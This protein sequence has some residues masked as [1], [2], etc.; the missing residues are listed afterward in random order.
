MKVCYDVIL[1]ALVLR[2]IFPVLN[3]QSST[4]SEQAAPTMVKKPPFDNAIQGILSTDGE[5]KPPPNQIP[6]ASQQDPSD[7]K[8]MPM[9]PMKTPRTSLMP[10]TGKFSKL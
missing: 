4:R 7:S 2:Y 1:L 10:S 6:E 3:L 8:M 5:P 9:F